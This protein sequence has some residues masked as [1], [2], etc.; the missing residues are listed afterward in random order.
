MTDRT[1]TL[2]TID[3]GDVTL[4]EPAWCAG[5]ADHRPGFRVDIFHC[6]PSRGVAFQGQEI[7]D[8]ALVLAPFA[9]VPEPGVSVS[10]LGKTLDPVGLYELAAVLERH[11]DQ[12]RN[13]AD[14]LT[15]LQDAAGGEGR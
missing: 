1:I 14:E 4:P 15:M 2:P 7:G 5:H 9:N 13:L 8:A 3:A 11:A 10:L 12:L 6:G